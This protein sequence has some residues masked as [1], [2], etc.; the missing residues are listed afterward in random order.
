MTRE[1]REQVVDDIYHCLSLLVNTIND[2]ADDSLYWYIGDGL[3]IIK[4]RGCNNIIF[5]CDCFEIECYLSDE[6]DYIHLKENFEDVNCGESPMWTLIYAMVYNEST[7]GDYYLED[8]L[9]ITDDN[10]YIKLEEEKKAYNYYFRCGEYDW[11]YAMDEKYPTK[12]WPTYCSE[13]TYRRK[14]YESRY[15][16][17]DTL[18]YL[19]IIDEDDDEE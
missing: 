17:G 7:K 2:G 16:D 9:L 3:K 10:K 5:K 12:T 8:F 11:N 15:K 14:H 1:E 13:F 6:N 4:D 19:D 18:W